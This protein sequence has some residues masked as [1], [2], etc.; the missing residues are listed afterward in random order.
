MDP[1]EAGKKFH[2]AERR[3]GVYREINLPHGNRAYKTLEH[4]PRLIY[5]YPTSSP[6]SPTSPSQSRSLGIRLRAL[7]AELDS[8]EAELADPSNPLL[9]L[10]DQEDGSKIDTGTLM[11][12]L[13]DVRGRLETV[14][15][16]KE[17]R[18]KLVGMIMEDESK[19]D[20]LEKRNE[21]ESNSA[22]VSKAKEAEKRDEEDDKLLAD[23]DKRVGELEDLIGSSS[24]ALD[25]V[26]RFHKKL[27]FYL[28]YLINI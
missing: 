7:Q 15:K 26:S 4:L 19:G 13:V 27:G 5:S 3:R 8:L 2:K 28:I 25:E 9:R 10:E 21:A 11:R 12:G 1:G 23:L 14:K 17:G 16:G 24:I 18:G 20:S 22:S 6:S